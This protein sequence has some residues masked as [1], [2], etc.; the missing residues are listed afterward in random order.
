VFVYCLKV[1]NELAKWRTRKLA[2]ESLPTTAV[3]RQVSLNRR[4]AMRNHRRFARSYRVKLVV[5][6][7]TKTYKALAATKIPVS[8]ARSGIMCPYCALELGFCAL[9]YPHSRASLLS[10]PPLVISHLRASFGIGESQRG[11]TQRQF[12]QLA[13]RSKG[14]LCWRGEPADNPRPRPR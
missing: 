7:N 9:Q 8:R 10:R 4:C 3:L 11:G 6:T 5:L 12:N 13:K 2:W 1:A 14:R